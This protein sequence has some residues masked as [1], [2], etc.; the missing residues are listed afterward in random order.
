MTVG[1]KRAWALV[2]LLS[3]MALLGALT[4]ALLQGLWDALSEGED[5]GDDSMIISE[6]HDSS[7]LDRVKK[8]KKRFWENEFR[9]LKI[10]KVDKSGKEIPEEEDSEEGPSLST[11]EIVK[12]AESIM[13]RPKG[14]TLD[15]L[16][17]SPPASIFPGMS[18]L[19]QTDTTL[20]QSPLPQMGPMLIRPPLPQRERPLDTS[21]R[22]PK[23]T[24][25]E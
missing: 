9:H 5:V 19:P 6:K 1:N 14:F 23:Y 3:G 21:A 11:E 18:P 15:R 12:E 13:E 20:F 25:H 7:Q 22:L 17:Q 4:G 8:G 24:P 10:V 2:A 16:F